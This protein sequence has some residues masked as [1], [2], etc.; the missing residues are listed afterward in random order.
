MV[1]SLADRWGMAPETGEGTTVWFEL[2]GTRSA[3]MA[4][5][6]HREEGSTI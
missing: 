5:G 6:R 2:D 1:A 4:A 3:V